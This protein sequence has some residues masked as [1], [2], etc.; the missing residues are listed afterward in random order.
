MCS[1]EYCT[2]ADKQLL[3]TILVSQAPEIF[4]AK[5]YDAS[6]DLWSVGVILYGEV[7]CRH[8]VPLTHCAPSAHV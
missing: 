6:V 7:Q 1:C 2:S 4:L 8:L 5:N 3:V